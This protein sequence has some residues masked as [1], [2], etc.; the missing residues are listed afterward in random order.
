[1]FTNNLYKLLFIVGLLAMLMWPRPAD[2]AYLSEGSAQTVQLHIG[3]GYEFPVRYEVDAT[4][5]EF[6]ARYGNWVQVRMIGWLLVEEVDLQLPD[7]SFIEIPEGYNGL[8]IGL[9]PRDDQT[10]E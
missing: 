4:N 6:T 1:M 3:P 8:I 2:A 7:F 10:E 5:L 9:M